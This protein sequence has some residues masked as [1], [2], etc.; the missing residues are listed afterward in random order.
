VPVQS[1]IAT[2]FCTQTSTTT[3]RPK[4]SYICDPSS[5]PQKQSVTGIVCFLVS[6]SACHHL[7]DFFDVSVM[8]SMH[9]FHRILLD[10]AKHIQPQRQLLVS[11]FNRLRNVE[12]PT[13]ASSR[14]PF[15]RDIWY[16]LALCAVNMSINNASAPRIFVLHGRSASGSHPTRARGH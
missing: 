16:V 8:L 13:L 1:A 2:R 9:S 6:Y 7:I 15:E 3:K 11:Q 4:S 12:D 10:S 14:H 5:V